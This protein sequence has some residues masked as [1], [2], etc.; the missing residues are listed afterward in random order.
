MPVI[1]NESIIHI[2]RGF[3]WGGWAGGYESLQNRKHEIKW[4]QIKTSW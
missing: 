1:E 3:T 2:L 4:I